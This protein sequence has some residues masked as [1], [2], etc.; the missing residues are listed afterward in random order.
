MVWIFT[1]GLV[2]VETY[3]NEIP[4][5]FKLYNNFPNPFNPS[6]TIKYSIPE[7]SKV[8]LTL[9]NLLGEEVTR[10]VDEEMTVGNYTAEF[11]ATNLP[12]GI[13]FYKLQAGTF[14]ETKKM[15][16]MN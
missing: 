4:K 8:S 9:F 1:T 13:Y 14:T 5:E 6:T 12:S 15:I 11:I 10:L 2:G 7:V 16:L 3:N